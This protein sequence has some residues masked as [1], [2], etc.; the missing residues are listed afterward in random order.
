MLEC[1]LLE[2]CELMGLSEVLRFMS[3]LLESQVIPV[4]AVLEDLLALGS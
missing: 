1:A 2:F 4:C 3:T